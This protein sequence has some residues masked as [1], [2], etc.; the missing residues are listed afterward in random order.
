MPVTT[1]PSV[2]STFEDNL[3]SLQPHIK[4]NV[5]LYLILRRYEAAPKLLAVTYVPDSAPVRQKMLFASTRLTLVRELGTEH[6]RDTVFVTTA[7][8]LSERGFK[9][10]D[11]HN[12]LDA[13]LTKEEKTL[14]EVKRAEQEVG[15]GTGT[16]EIHLSKS[17]SMPVAADA[18]AAMKEV[19]RGGDRIVAMLVSWIIDGT[20]PA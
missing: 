19:G 6:F 3:A 10:L 8:E 4:P 2:A 12:K 15:S 18:I 20:G 14:G 9:K 16:R 13:P 5:A 7:E 17:L 1:L 11:A